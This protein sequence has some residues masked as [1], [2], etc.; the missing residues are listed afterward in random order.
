MRITLGTWMSLSCEFCVLSGTE[1]SAMDL[2]LVQRSPAE[3]GV[4]E[5]D[6]EATIMR[7][8]WT[9]MGCGNMETKQR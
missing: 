3:C 2:S 6:R 8:P 1:V 5:Y 9:T 4:S 7:W